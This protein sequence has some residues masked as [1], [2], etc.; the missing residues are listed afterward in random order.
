MSL[1]LLL[2]YHVLQMLNDPRM[3]HTPCFP[4]HALPV[5]PVPAPL[6]SFPACHS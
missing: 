6:S 1:R 3:L 2:Q 4:R 5:F